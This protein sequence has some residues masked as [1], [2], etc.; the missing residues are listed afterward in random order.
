MVVLLIFE[1]LA[2]LFLHTVHEDMSLFVI[3]DNQRLIYENRPNYKGRYA[4]A[5]VHINGMGLRG[6]DFSLMKK[7]GEIRI[8]VF[9]DSI[10]FG[11]GVSD[12]ETF[13]FQLEKILNQNNLSSSFEVLNAGVIG[14]NTEQELEY[15]L[16]KGL[17]FC[18]DIV[19]VTFFH[20][21]LGNKPEFIVKNGKLINYRDRGVSSL[22]LR[23]KEFFRYHSVLYNFLAERY[24]VLIEILRFKLGSVSDDGNRDFINLSNK[25]FSFSDVDLDGWNENKAGLEK[26]HQLAIKNNVIP[27]FTI[28]P[29]LVQLDDYPFKNAHDEFMSFCTSK[30]Y[31]C[32]DLFEAFK[33]KK[34]AELWAG[35]QNRHP[36]KKGHRIAASVLAKNVRAIFY[37]DAH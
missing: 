13:P 33:G 32:I 18:P 6:N 31:F 27:I 21:D 5:L 25:K 24:H 15:F 3:S 28:F 7:K 37:V 20:N 36:N 34:D 1:G 30:K 29:D 11:H 10:V 26:L 14:Y 4:D 19:I 16:K 35:L 8:I 9:G 23:V 22:H 12:D 17:S 2:R